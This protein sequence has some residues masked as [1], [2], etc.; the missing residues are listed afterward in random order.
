MTGRETLRMFAS[1]RGVPER[2]IEA[3]VEDLTD[4][5]LLRDHIEKQVK[6]LRSVVIC[7]ILF[8]KTI[9]FVILIISYLFL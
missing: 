3:V 5:L 7:S 2:S 1:L 9:Q 8:L 4:K 6:E